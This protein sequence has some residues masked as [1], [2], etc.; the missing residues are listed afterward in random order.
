M[1]AELGSARQG[2]GEA[3]VVFFWGDEGWQ[4]VAGTME[5]GLYCITWPAL[6]SMTS[7]GSPPPAHPQRL[8]SGEGGRAG[9]AARRWGRWGGGGGPAE[10]FDAAGRGARGDSR[11][12]S[13]FRQAGVPK[14][15]QTDRTR[16]RAATPEGARAAM[17]TTRRVDYHA[18]QV[19]AAQKEYDTNVYPG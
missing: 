13:I 1:D 9:A 18:A 4:A 12:G 5:A 3:V 2:R 17:A 11:P 19:N 16:P 10:D 15:G 14:A 7:M 8:G 6:A